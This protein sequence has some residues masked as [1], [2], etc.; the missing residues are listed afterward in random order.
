MDGDGARNDLHLHLKDIYSEGQ[1]LY[2]FL[3]FP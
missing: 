1:N 3:Y 2:L